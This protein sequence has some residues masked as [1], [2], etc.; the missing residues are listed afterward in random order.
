MGRRE[1]ASGFVPRDDERLG[2][3][4]EQVD[5]FAKGCWVIEGRGFHC[6][7]SRRKT[8]PSNCMPRVPGEPR[9]P[10]PKRSPS[11]ANSQP[12]SGPGEEQE[13]RTRLPQRD[14][15]RRAPALRRGEAT[16]T[17]RSRRCGLAGAGWSAGRASADVCGI[18]RRQHY[19]RPSSADPTCLP[20]DWLAGSREM[21]GRRAP[22]AP[23]GARG[24]A[25]ARTSCSKFA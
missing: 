2:V 10:A 20:R 18:R 1:A 25:E 11:I 22:R 5:C 21:P 12:R 4:R 13:M 3:R 14:A 17:E 7:T 24:S 16:L 6:Y 15:M 9:M 23:S 8:E 19:R